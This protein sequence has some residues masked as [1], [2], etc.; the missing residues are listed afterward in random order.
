VVTDSEIQNEFTPGSG[1]L[2]DGHPYLV[3]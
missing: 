2:D 3:I 1:V